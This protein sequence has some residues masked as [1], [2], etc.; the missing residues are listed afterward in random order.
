VAIVDKVSEALVW[1]ALGAW[2]LAL[3]FAAAH[4]GARRARMRVAAGVA[5]AFAAA[6]LLAHA[7]L[8]SDVSVGCL[9]ALWIGVTLRGIG[10]E[11]R[12]LRAEPSFAHSAASVRRGGKRPELRV[13]RGGGS[14]LPPAR[15]GHGTHVRP[16]A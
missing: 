2:A 11:F 10:A 13:I 14:R 8:L 6:A 5:Q 3:A 15:S 4:E 1:I 9:A 7:A 12:G 16:N